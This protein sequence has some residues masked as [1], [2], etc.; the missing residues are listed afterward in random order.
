[1]SENGRVRCPSGHYWEYV[2][3][4]LT[5]SIL[6]HRTPSILVHRSTSWSESVQ[7]ASGYDWVRLGEI[8][9]ELLRRQHLSAVHGHFATQLFC[10]GISADY[11]H[12]KLYGFF[13][14]RNSRKRL[15]G[16]Q[17]EEWTGWV[18]LVCV[19]GWR[20]GLGGCALVDNNTETY[21]RCSLR[22]Y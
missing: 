11:L 12:A 19:G 13:Q 9:W 16:K 21:R 8:G 18:M 4:M 20:E 1:M 3:N 5:P 10:D 2:Q 22:P 7:S 15:T 6:V 14:F 17:D